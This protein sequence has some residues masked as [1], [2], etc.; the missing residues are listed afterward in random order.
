MLSHL[1]KNLFKL[2][3]TNIIKVNYDRRCKISPEIMYPP[4]SVKQKQLF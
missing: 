4:Y 3:D 1:R 2:D